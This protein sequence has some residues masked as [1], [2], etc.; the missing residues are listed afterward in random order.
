MPVDRLQRLRKFL[1]QL[2][3]LVTLLLSAT[4]LKVRKE[5]CVT[6]TLYSVEIAATLCP[7]FRNILTFLAQ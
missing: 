5:H 2:L 3:E 1:K 6:H 4:F 7:M